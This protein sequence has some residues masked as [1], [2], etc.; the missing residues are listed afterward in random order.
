MFLLK[1]NNVI[2]TLPLSIQASNAAAGLPD[3]D[4]AQLPS[5]E[6]NS[7]RKFHSGEKLIYQILRG[8]EHRSGSLTVMFLYY[9]VVGWVVSY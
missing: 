5:S 8:R 6:E 1:I 7:E 9:S 4:F 2:L 3:E